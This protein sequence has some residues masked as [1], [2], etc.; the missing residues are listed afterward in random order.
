MKHFYSCTI[1]LTA[2]KRVTRLLRFV[3][4]VVPQL[5]QRSCV[6]RTRAPLQ[7]KTSA[8]RPRLPRNMF[9]VMFHWLGCATR[10]HPL[11]SIPSIAIDSL[12]TEMSIKISKVGLPNALA[13]VARGIVNQHHDASARTSSVFSLFSFRI[14][15]RSCQ[16]ERK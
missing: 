6:Y 5:S 2:K 4:V 7:R 15:G 12:P 3:A 8:Y 9:L 10:F 14:E 1:I 16:K 13:R 11:Y